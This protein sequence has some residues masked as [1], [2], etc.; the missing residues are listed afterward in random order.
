MRKWLIATLA[1]ALIAWPVVLPVRAGQPKPPI[2]VRFETPRDFGYHIGDLVP[3]VLLIYAESGV[4][5]DLESLPRPGETIGPFEVRKVWIEHSTDAGGPSYRIEFTLQSFVP[6]TA[7]VGLVLPAFELRFALPEDRSPDGEYTY[8]AGTLPAQVFFLSRTATGSG[9]L[10]PFKGSLL[11]RRGWLFWGALSLGA[12]L[13][14]AGAGVL[15]S[16][17]VRWWKRRFRRQQSSA[18]RRA[19]RTLRVLRERYLACEEKTPDLFVKGS[20]ALRRFLSEEC[21]IPARVQTVHQIT[22]RFS[23]HPLQ[24]EL[25]GVLERCDRVIYDGHHPSASEKQDIIREMAAL[26]ERLEHVGCPTGGRN[27]EAR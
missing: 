22:E 27:G 26:I 21:G 13:L 2:S 24:K 18:G 14:A 7:A 9:T 1:S 11:P 16:D 25:E 17:A 15:I 20:G 8:R 10:R 12:A 6:A 23:G 5:I 4:V 3:L 19:V